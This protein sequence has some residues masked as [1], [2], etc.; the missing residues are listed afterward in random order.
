MKKRILAVFAALALCLSGLA[1]SFAAFATETPH[2][3]AIN[4]NLLQLEDRY[5]PIIADGLYYVPYHA[6]DV[7]STGV[8]LGI[9]P[10]YNS[11]IRVLTIYNREKV[12]SFDLTAGTC[13]DRDGEAY[14]ARAVTRN[15]Q[16]YVPA[17]FVCD[18]FGLTYSYFPET[19]YGPMIR[20]CSD[21]ARL[22]DRHFL[23]AAQM[24]MEDRL[25]SWRKNQTP[26]VTPT[27]VSPSVTVTPTPTPTPSHTEG[28]SE[29]RVY[30]AFYAEQTDGLTVL[31]ERLDWYQTKALFFFPA[32]D[33]ARYDEAIRRVLI[34]G[35][36]VGLALSGTTQEELTACAAEGSRLLRQIV[37]MDA[38][39]VLLPE[40]AKEEFAPA[41]RA[42]GWVVWQTDV[43]A[44]PDGQSV[45][46]QT[47]EIK[48]Q[49][50][51]CEGAVYILSD[52]SVTASALMTLLLPEL[53]EDPYDLR[54][55][56]E[57]Q[58]QKEGS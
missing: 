11:A 19:Q 57:T 40:Q 10:V 43:D 35:H 14:G 7:S 25:R 15:G 48:R 55:A 1:A 17:R 52:G 28:R 29:V 50:E 2:F 13:T 45:S 51:A 41:L 30:P 33:L 24:Q 46:A 4:E 9:Y 3:L 26:A 20:I 58:I 27:P 16:V 53:M 6:L 38:R 36:A 5:I 31:L 37:C 44:R 47:A 21:S 54:L 12:I 22:N 56:V 34:E 49:L 42:A 32:N 23:A 18:F 39:T 8:D